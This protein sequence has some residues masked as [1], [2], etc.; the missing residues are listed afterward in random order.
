MK[1][2]AKIAAFLLVLPITVAPFIACVAQAA[3]TEEQACC[4]EMGGQC[5]SDE[6]PSSH[7]CCKTLPAPVQLA[8]AKSPFSLDYHALTFALPEQTA[9]QSLPEPTP[10]AIFADLPHSPPGTPPTSGVLRI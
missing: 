6:M 10:F 8:T 7:S 5:G 1:R 9:S 2:T 4:R 3:T